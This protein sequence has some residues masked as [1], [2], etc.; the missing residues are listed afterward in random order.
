MDSD[1]NLNGYIK[2]TPKAA[3]YP[4]RS[5]LRI[6]GLKSQQDLG[7]KKTKLAAVVCL[8]IQVQLTLTETELVHHITTVLGSFHC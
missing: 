5:I 4:L 1:L 3:S 6:K 7:G 8:Q 2:A